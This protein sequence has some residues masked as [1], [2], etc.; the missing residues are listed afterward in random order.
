MVL[1]NCPYY[2]LSAFVFDLFLAIASILSA[3]A[4]TMIGAINERT[5]TGSVIMSFMTFK[6]T[7]PP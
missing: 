2:A 4:N 1:I 5:W 6:A 7:M 3:D